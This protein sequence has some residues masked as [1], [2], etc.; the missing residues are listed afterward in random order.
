MAMV[1]S[2][3]APP[4]EATSNMALRVPAVAVLTMTFLTEASMGK[5]EAN[6]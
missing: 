2:L 5:S 3:V 6:V 1:F 4:K